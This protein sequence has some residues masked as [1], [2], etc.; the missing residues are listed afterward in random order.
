[1]I[2]LRSLR[3]L[4]ATIVPLALLSIAIGCQQKSNEERFLESAPP[5][6]TGDGNYASSEDMY[7]QQGYP[8]ATEPEATTPTPEAAADETPASEPAAPTEVIPAPEESAAPI[9]EPPADEAA[10]PTETP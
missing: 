2:R 3:S 4:F 8:G 9:L 1:M 7:Q 6:I 5:G 10:A